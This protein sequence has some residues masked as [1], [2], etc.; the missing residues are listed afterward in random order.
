MQVLRSSYDTF[1]LRCCSIIDTE[2]QQRAQLVFHAHD[3]GICDVLSSASAI[4]PYA[5][6][7]ISQ[8][9]HDHTIVINCATLDELAAK[10][11]E[12]G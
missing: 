12:G 9:C 10:L 11:C 8:T 2:M 5:K 1:H 3:C 7:S 6:A 4:D